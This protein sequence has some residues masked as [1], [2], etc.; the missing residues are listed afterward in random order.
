MGGASAAQRENC[1]GPEGSWAGSGSAFGCATRPWISPGLLVYVEMLNRPPN[2]SSLN[3]F[4][5]M[6]E[7]HDVESRNALSVRLHRDLFIEPKI[8]KLAKSCIFG[9]SFH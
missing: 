5:N 7:D 2:T 6:F 1:S 8:G 9:N 4:R 3:R